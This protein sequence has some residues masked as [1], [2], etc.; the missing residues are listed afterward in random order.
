MPGTYPCTIPKLDKNFLKL[1]LASGDSMV[2]VGANGS[3]KTRLGV[4]LE[5]QIPINKVQRIAAHKSLRIN[6]QLN[7]IALERADKLL[8]FGHEQG[9]TIKQAGRWGNNP[10]T[11]LL[12][13]F[14]AL[15]QTLF[16]KHNRAASKHLIER[17][18]DPNVFIPTTELELLKSIWDKLLPHRSLEISEASVR[19]RSDPTSVTITYAGSEMSDGERAIFYFLG[20]SLLAPA[21]S[22]I[23]V[24]EPEAHIHKAILSPL[25]RAIESARPD[26]SYVY[27]THDLD[28]V[29]QHELATKYYLRAYS[30]APTAWD[31]EELPKDTGLPEQMIVELV[32]SRKPILFVEGDRG[33]YD[34]SIYQSIYPDFTIIPIGGCEVVIHSVASFKN[35]AT[36]HWL[37][38][39]GLVDADARDPSERVR[40]SAQ[41]IYVL[42]VAE[43]ENLLLL[44]NVFIALAQALISPDPED[45]LKKLTDEVMVEAMNNVDRVAAR[46]TSRQLDSRLK[47]VEVV[48]KDLAKLQKEFAIQLG[49]IDPTSIFNDFRARLVEKINANDLPGVL[50][51]YDNKGLLSRAANSLGVRDQKKLVQKLVFLLN[52]KGGT[53]LRQELSKVLPKIPG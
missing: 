1:I 53:L 19:V 29:A 24:D 47:M 27:M 38:V 21:D 45:L 9:E 18:I 43:V 34:L 46:Y 3:G 10:A 4:L 50:E 51:L 39:R 48:A 17:K 32:G 36:L 14:D 52:D 13:D 40:L 28:F 12:S 41:D 15:L 31:I 42:P 37:T 16:A 49:T 6:D 11:H 8:R 23:I 26:C 5:N 2:I 44:P 35:R 7:L 33:S 22:V 20:Q 25:W 30:H